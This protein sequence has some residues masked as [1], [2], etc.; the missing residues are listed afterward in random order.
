MDNTETTVETGAEFDAN[1]AV[2]NLLTE[3]TEAPEAETQNEEV[4][5]EEARKA[6]LNSGLNTLIEDGW[7]SEEILEFSQDPTV[8][9]DI[10]KNGKTVRQA[11]RAFL[12][13]LAAADK[14]EAKSVKHGVPT[15]K[16]ASGNGAGGRDQIAEMSDADFDKFYKQAMSDSL[17]GKKR[18]L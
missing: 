18:R 15:V 8:R 6:E 9:E 16:T 3:N 10:Q 2:D 5:P 4:S 13:R 7:S 11:A 14:A 1:A 17:A 12:R